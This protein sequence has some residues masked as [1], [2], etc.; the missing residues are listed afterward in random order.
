MPVFASRADFQA[1]L[2]EIAEQ[3][4]EIPRQ[5]SI[6]ATT[7]DDVLS[8]MSEAEAEPY[9]SQILFIPAWDVMQQGQSDDGESE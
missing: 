7:L 1:A 9:L 8:W 3:D 6:E 4:P 2:L 5:V